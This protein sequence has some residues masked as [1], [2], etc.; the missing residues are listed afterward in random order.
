M[1]NKTKIQKKTKQNKNKTKKMP[2]LAGQIQVGDYVDYEVVSDWASSLLQTQSLQT[3]QTQTNPTSSTAD[4]PNTAP[5]GTAEQK[6]PPVKPCPACVC[7]PAGHDLWLVFIAVVG[8]L[9]AVWVICLYFRLRCQ[10]WP[11]QAMNIEAKPVTKPAY[12]PT[13]DKASQVDFTAKEPAIKRR[14]RHREVGLVREDEM[15]D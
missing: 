4:Q 9:L 14:K 2:P 8:W 5:A 1:K 6:C 10:V 15:I 12:K 11:G 7:V 3:P 13:A